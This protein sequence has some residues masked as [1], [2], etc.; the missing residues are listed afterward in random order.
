[1]KV[2]IEKWIDWDKAKKMMLRTIGKKPA[3]G[4]EFPDREEKLQWLIGEHSHIKVVTWCIDVDE[5]MQWVGVHLLRH[6]HVLPYIST[7]RGDNNNDIDKVLSM[8]RED[9]L[10]A[11]P[12][13]RN[14]YRDYRMQGSENDHS[15]VV[16]AQTLINISRKRLCARA[17]HETRAVWNMV[18]SAIREHDPEMADVMVPNCVYRG[19]C[20]EMNTCGYY[21][22]KAF[23]RWLNDYRNL[24]GRG[25]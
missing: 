14:H 17:S 4:R 15:F 20:P 18:R 19:F 21:N 1:M 12:H 5:L 13:A 3:K 9:I 16:N 23:R 11:D 6:E 7:Q 8:I 25:F 24:I 22:T 2:N 10:E